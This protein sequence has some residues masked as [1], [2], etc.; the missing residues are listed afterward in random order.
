M[1]GLEICS[2]LWFVFGGGFEGFDRGCE[3]GGGLVRRGTG[4]LFFFIGVFLI[5]FRILFVFFIVVF[6]GIFGI[7]GV[8]G[9]VLFVLFLV[10]VFVPGY[11]FVVGGVRCCV[12]LDIEHFIRLLLECSLPFNMSLRRCSSLS[13]TCLRK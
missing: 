5:V 2:W 13:I 10:R 6:F 3:V 4:R 7:F 11:F 9:V 12:M 8:V 1:R